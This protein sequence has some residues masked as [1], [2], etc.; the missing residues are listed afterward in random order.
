MATGLCFHHDILGSNRFEHIR[1]V[2]IEDPVAEILNFS[3]Y[4][5]PV[6]R[7]RIVINRTVTGI[8]DKKVAAPLQFGTKLEQRS[9]NVGPGCILDPL[10]LKAVKSL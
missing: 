9:N 6:T 4:G 3:L 7:Q 10:H 2:S 5:L 1:D 8:L